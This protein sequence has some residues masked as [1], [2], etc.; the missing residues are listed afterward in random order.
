MNET[1]TVSRLGA[2][3]DG[4]ADTPAGPV[5]I[6]FALPGETVTAVRTKDRATLL[7]VDDPSPDRVAPVCRHFGVCGGC[8][9]QHLAR[10]PYVEWKRQKVVQALASRGIEF[11]VSEV[12]AGH[13]GSRR[14]T[15]FT[16]RRTEAGIILGYNQASSHHIVDVSE[17]P[18]VVPEIQAA[19]GKLWAL[20][21]LLCN[22]GEPFHLVVT[23]TS[24][25]LDVAAEGSGKLTD[26]A[27]RALGDFVV[28]ERFARLAV[29]GEIIV[30]PKKPLV[31][32][33]T[34]SVAPPPGAFLQAVA[35]AE[36]V[37]AEM[38]ATHLRR[39]RRIA[40]LFAGTG[41]FTFRL[42]AMAEVHAV[43][44]GDL[45]MAALDRAY[46]YSRGL[47]PVTVE[48]RDLFRR[49]LT[50]RELGHF[51]GV[52]FDPPRAGAEEQ[53]VQLARSDVPLVAAISCN[54]ATLARD[55]RILI[56]GGYS[57]K[58]VTPVDQFIWSPHVEVVALLEKPKRRR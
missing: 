38:T 7:S 39:A 35:T 34:V 8:S 31:R 44:G 2:Q 26:A 13:G 3:G 43:E 58:Q 32:F 19:I 11:P 41:A 47:R 29:D 23:L 52:V 56:D 20:A 40:D 22:T 9:V 55:L 51:D 45:A 48:T 28:R 37:M 46:R 5:Y 16:A 50:S 27:R 36:G 53:S 57:L 33:G 12:I 17:C 49:P 30:E 25:G 14:R 6:R 15:V 1:F 21:A 42:A 54:P 10:Q 24:A 4:I 18:V